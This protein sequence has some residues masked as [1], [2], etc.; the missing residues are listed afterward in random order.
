M[1]Y[2]LE[3]QERDLIKLC[4]V[5]LLKGKVSRF[6]ARSFINKLFLL[7]G[8]AVLSM[9]AKLSD[10]HMIMSAL[11]KNQSTH[12]PGSHLINLCANSCKFINK[13]IKPLG[14]Q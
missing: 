8:H 1:N 5:L 7:P 13:K 11:S 14:R 6:S 3:D 12:S 4:V 9:Q 2:F 10:M